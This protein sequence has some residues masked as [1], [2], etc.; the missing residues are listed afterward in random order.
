[1]KLKLLSV[2]VLLSVTVPVF[3]ESDSADVHFAAHFGTS[4]LLTGLVFG[5]A[6]TGFTW[7]QDDSLV[8][9]ATAVLAMGAMR[10]AF[11]AGP[12]DQINT[13]GIV[14]DAAGIAFF[15][16]TAKMFHWEFNGP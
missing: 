12:G 13:A 7:K 14:Q 3:G 6:N 4:Y 1:M 10:Q 5:L 2:L 9:A 8:F 16:L 11:V 15:C